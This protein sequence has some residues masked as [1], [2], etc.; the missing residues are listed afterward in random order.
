MNIA[1]AWWSQG[2]GF[3]VLMVL[4][5]S[6]NFTF[7]DGS[8]NPSQSLCI[9]VQPVTEGQGKNQW[10][11]SGKQWPEISIQ[12]GNDGVCSPRVP[13]GIHAAT[14]WDTRSRHSHPHS[15]DKK[16][17]TQI[18][19]NPG[20]RIQVFLI[21]RLLF[22]YCR[23]LTLPGGHLILARILWSK[24]GCINKWVDLPGAIAMQ[25]EEQ[26]LSSS[27][28]EFGGSHWFPKKTALFFS[29]V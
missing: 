16:M 19:S 5:I 3:G 12:N 9:Y 8:A 13:P 10:L 17:K 4:L 24:A 18:H 2:H 26:V 20:I 23:R 14:A 22:L 11:S 27:C 25:P 6:L 15:A 29:F 1:P 28:P 7:T 21:I